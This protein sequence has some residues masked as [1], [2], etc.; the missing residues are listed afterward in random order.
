MEWDV[1]YAVKE[2][3]EERDVS[4][5]ELSK[6]MGLRKSFI[7]NVESRKTK[8]KY[9]L[10]H[11]YLIAAF[12]EVPPSRFFRKNSYKISAEVKQRFAGVKQEIAAKKEAKEKSK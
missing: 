6:A 7:G 1:I 4:Q 12:F 3:R 8:S 9:N 10:G 5:T 11:L 2:L